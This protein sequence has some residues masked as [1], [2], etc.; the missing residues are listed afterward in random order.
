MRQM[1]RSEEKKDAGWAS[2]VFD[3]APYVT[4]SMA[5]LVFLNV[6]GYI[7]VYPDAKVVKIS[8]VFDRIFI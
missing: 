8:E 3:K 5:L 6:V 7:C 2:A 1:R 4:V